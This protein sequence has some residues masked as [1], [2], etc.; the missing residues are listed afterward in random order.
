MIAYVTVELVE[1][2]DNH[3][4]KENNAVMAVHITIT[5]KLYCLVTKGRRELG[6]GQFYQPGCH[7]S[8]IS[9]VAE[10]R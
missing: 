4:V 8:N 5:L 10:D 9:L 7:K 1:F 2:A 3:N 6:T